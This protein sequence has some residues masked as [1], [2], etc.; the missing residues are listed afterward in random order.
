MTLHMNWNGSQRPVVG[1]LSTSCM[2]SPALKLRPC[3][4][5]LSDKWATEYCQTCLTQ[6]S[7][8]GGN[9][10]SL[11]TSSQFCFMIGATIAATRSRM[12]SAMSWSSPLRASMK[13]MF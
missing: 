11:L 4:V 12:S 3:G 1:D 10:S 8:F 2:H 7:R 13:L 6:N 9:S 5:R